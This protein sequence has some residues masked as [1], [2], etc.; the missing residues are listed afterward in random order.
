MWL[1]PLGVLATLTDGRVVTKLLLF[2]AFGLAQIAF[3]FGLSAAEALEP[4]PFG[5]LLLRNLSLAA[6]AM[7]IAARAGKR[8]DQCR[9]PGASWPVRSTYSTYEPR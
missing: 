1:L 3:P 6:W 8:G 5:V 7:A 4:W 2:G 9:T